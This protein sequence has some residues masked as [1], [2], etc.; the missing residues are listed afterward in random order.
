MSLRNFYLNQ[1]QIFINTILS[2]F[3]VWENQAMKKTILWCFFFSKRNFP[4][5]CATAQSCTLRRH[6]D[7]WSSNIPSPRH[8]L[9]LHEKQK[10][11]LDMRRTRRKVMFPLKCGQS[12]TKKMHRKK[13]AN[14]ALSLKLRQNV[15][16]NMS[17]PLFEERL[18]R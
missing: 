6:F 15:Q 8:S 12:P 16:C 4:L 11:W 10:K 13:V 9:S 7:N 17:F 14:G 1:W 2:S 3:I 5:H 18:A